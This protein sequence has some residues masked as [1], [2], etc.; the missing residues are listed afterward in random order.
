M[1]HEAV[2]GVEG[3]GGLDTVLGSHVAWVA[4]TLPS[5]LVSGPSGPFPTA[6]FA[7]AS[8][9]SWL[10]GPELTG[11]GELGA[12][13]GNACGVFVGAGAGV[14]PPNTSTTAAATPMTMTAAA[15]IVAIRMPRFFLLLSGGP[16]GP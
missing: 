12:E 10:L 1:S 2:E 4:V 5:A 16:G 8:A 11:V 9:T 7:M 3:S 6:R 13:L 15:E 14:D